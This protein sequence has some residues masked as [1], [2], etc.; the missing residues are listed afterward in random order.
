MKLLLDHPET[1]DRI[2]AI[3][4]VAVTGAPTPLLDAAEWSALKQICAPPPAN[5]TGNAHGQ[6]SRPDNAT[7]HPQRTAGLAARRL[8]APHR[9]VLA[10]RDVHRRH[11]RA[12]GR[13]R[14]RAGALDAGRRPGAG[15][16]RDPARSR[17]RHRYLARGRRRRPACGR[18]FVHRFC[19]HRLSALS[20]HQGLPAAGDLRHHAP[21][22]SIRRNSTPSRGCGRATPIRSPMRAST[23]RSSSTRP[24]PISSPT[25]PRRRRRR[26]TTPR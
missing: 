22:R 16:R 24:I 12:L 8:G 9:A 3:D 25:T 2:A 10:R 20:R 19:A 4:A 1:R 21:I 18:R 26:P 13:A 17:R 15:L 7:P 5:A 11:H 23:P 14:H 6:R